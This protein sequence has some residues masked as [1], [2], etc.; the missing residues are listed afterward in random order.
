[1]LLL[2]GCNKPHLFTRSSA[3]A[4]ISDS[5][6]KNLF[7]YSL[8]GNRLQDLVVELQMALKP[9]V[10]TQQGSQPAP[11]VNCTWARVI[12]VQLLLPLP[13]F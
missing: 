13:L 4:Q 2:L 11:V 12:P 9:S 8:Q 7:C 1:M 5:R 10:V 6:F 3:V